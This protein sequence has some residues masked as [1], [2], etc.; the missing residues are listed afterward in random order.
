M[1]AGNVS[2]FRFCFHFRE[3]TKPII[4]ISFSHILTAGNY[5][6]TVNQ[7]ECVIYTQK[8]K[9]RWTRLLFAS[10]MMKIMTENIKHGVSSLTSQ[11]CQRLGMLGR[12]FCSHTTF[13]ISSTD[14]SDWTR[15]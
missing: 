10:I 1:N 12:S 7:L 4:I 11:L 15:S 14:G 2:F 3:T 9:N 13:L 8:I 5:W 6:F